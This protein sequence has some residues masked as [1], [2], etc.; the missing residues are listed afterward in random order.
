MLQSRIGQLQKI[1]ASFAQY[2]KPQQ[3]VIQTASRSSPNTSSNSTSAPPT[4]KKAVVFHR[5]NGQVI[6]SMEDVPNYPAGDSKGPQHTIKGILRDIRCS[7]PNV[8]ALTVDRAGKQTTL[9]TN[10]YMKIV[11]TTTYNSNDEIKPCTGIED[12]K[13][14]V[15]YAEVTDNNVAGQIL[16]IELSK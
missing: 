16:A 2:E 3:I 10:D 13:A 11:F 15:K 14:A 9:Y 1:Q 7:S 8:L 6:G 12:M 4:M 5:V